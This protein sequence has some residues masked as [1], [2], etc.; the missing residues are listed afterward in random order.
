MSRSA[1]RRR[2][3]WAALCGVLL[4]A[5][6]L[7]AGSSGY[8]P[9][10]NAPR[11]SVPAG[12]QWR[13]EHLFATPAAWDQ[14][15]AAVNAELP[16]LSGYAGRLS[17]SPESLHACLESLFRLRN[18]L[19]NLYVYADTRYN[20]EQS[21]AEAKTRQGRIAM[22]LPVYGQTV[23]YIDPEILAIDQARLDDFLA[24]H[25]GLRTYAFYL[26]NV[27]RLKAHTLSPAEERILALTGNVA[28]NPGE[29]H[30]AL[31]NVDLTFPEIVDESGQKVPLTLTGFSRYRASPVYEVRRQAAAAF[32]G[33]LRQFENTLA[34]S[35][36]GAVKAHIM[37]KE[38]RGYDSCLEASL[39]PDNISPAAYRMLID[40]INAHVGSTL[41]RYVDLRRRVLGLDGPLTFAHLY[42]PLL[43]RAEADYDYQQARELI[44][45][46]LAP[47]GRDYVTRLG[48][49]LD[50]ANGWIDVYPNADKEGGAY[51]QGIANGPGSHPYVLMNFD[52]SLDAVSTL[53][54]EYGH[55]LHSVY[56]AASQPPVYA[57]Y[58][59]FLAEVASTCNEALLLDKLLREAPDAATKLK[60]LNQRLE[61]IRLTIFRQTLFAE[62][63]L[64]FHEYAEQGQPLT[65]EFLNGLYRELI[66]KYYGPHYEI[67]ENDE[68]EWAF[69]PH[70][71]RNFYVFTYATGLTS[72]LSLAQQIQAQGAPAADRYIDGLLKAGSSAPPLEILRRAGV[73]LETPQPILD[74]LDL[75][76]RTVV[77]FDR[78]WAE[79]GGGKAA[80]G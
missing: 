36:D 10:P 25:A 5:P 45:T 8:V 3:A 48:A 29:V 76:E 69:I 26:E 68:V 62:F 43:P 22:M 44:V 16:Q 33:T 42:N 57:D 66:Q 47:L 21:N 55:A 20:V 46:A 65:A 64:R 73:D 34:T 72:G 1:D 58:T 24:R 75:F 80:R 9:D 51:S 28:G 37:A 59:T 40:T 2:L 52:N 56:S 17:E 79:S 71:Y 41:H 38:A 27:R 32:F 67:G 15:F 77:E 70:F 13:P 23:A 49:G 35:L 50:P 7:S 53:A 61:S 18:R 14:E 39:T 12:F 19:Y 54:H 78:L 4:L 31:L 74:M 30:G 11:S 6:A 60:L 63:E